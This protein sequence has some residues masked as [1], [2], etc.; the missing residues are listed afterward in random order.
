MLPDTVFDRYTPIVGKY[1]WID[2]VT[3]GQEKDHYLVRYRGKLKTESSQAYDN[4]AAELKAENLTPL[5]RKEQDRAAI[6]LVSGVVNARPSN[7][8]VNLILFFLTL[9]S[10]MFAGTLYTYDGPMQPGLLGTIQTVL[11]NIWVGLPFAV[12]LLAILVAHEFGHYLAG[13]YHRTHVTLPYFIPFP[14][15]PFGTMGAFIRLKSRRETSASCWI[16]E[17]PARLLGW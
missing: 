2:D 5:F 9:F 11:E 1:L 15:S 6:F 8:W 16:L 13:R 17:L 7:P 10:M 14:L 3:T 12:A 4:L